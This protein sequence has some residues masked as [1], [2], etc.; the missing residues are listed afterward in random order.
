ATLVALAS[1][2]TVWRAVAGLVLLLG[3]SAAAFIWKDFTFLALSS[4]VALTWAILATLL[5][6]LPI[7]ARKSWIAWLLP[8]LPFLYAAWVLLPALS[9]FR[10]VSLDSRYKGLLTLGDFR[11]YLLLMATPFLV[12][13][14]A[15]LL[16]LGLRNFLARSP[17]AVA[18]LSHVAALALLV[19]MVTAFAATPFYTIPHDYRLFTL[20]ETIEAYA[21]AIVSNNLAWDQERITWKFAFGTFGWLDTHYPDW[22]YAVARWLAV[23]LIV[24]LP[25][26]TRP[27]REKQ[28]FIAFQ[29]FLLFGFGLSLV[30]TPM[31]LR[32]A[33]VTPFDI[34]SS[35]FALPMIPIA[36]LPLFVQVEAPGRSR[37][38][39]A[40]FLALVA[41][42]VWT[43]ITVLGAR[44]YFGS[45]FPI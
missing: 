39:C 2:R 44:Y 1:G 35:R 17:A 6:R 36:L 4:A 25:V 23:A 20:P 7:M 42:N 33:A 34:P 26:I 45:P 41:L 18:R 24:A 28:P 3:S 40:A 22:V 19:G 15:A 5:T 31:I 37:V 11:P 21:R 29:L 32:M 9:R 13:A 10:P 16:A 30:S 38:L 12:V 43:A 8:A 14:A 27:F